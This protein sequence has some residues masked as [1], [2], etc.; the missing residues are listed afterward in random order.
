M[1]GPRRR[2]IDPVVGGD[3]VDEK[4]CQAEKAIACAFDL[5]GT[6]LDGATNAAAVAFLRCADTTPFTTAAKLA[7]A[8]APAA[9]L[10]AAAVDACVASAEAD[11]LLAAASKLFNAQYAKST[12]IPA[13]AV[14]DK[15]LTGPTYDSVKRAACAAGS[16]APICADDAARACVV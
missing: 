10:K 14:A 9:G 11:A 8:C 13:V 5:A 4:G 12:F 15:P 3:C 2:D 1:R 7:A 16:K 6:K